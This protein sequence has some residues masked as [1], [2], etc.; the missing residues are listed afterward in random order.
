M[1]AAN[2]VTDIE[3]KRAVFLSI[4]DQSK[5]LQVVKQFGMPARRKDYN[6]LLVVLTE[7]HSSAPSEIVQRFKFNSRFQHAGES[8][9][10]YLAE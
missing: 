7:H 6:E 8:V 5:D 10:T 1:H 9:A 3:R 4:I 2:G